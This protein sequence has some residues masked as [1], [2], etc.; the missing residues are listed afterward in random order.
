MTAAQARMTL[1][2]VRTQLGTMLKSDVAVDPLARMDPEHGS[3]RSFVSR[4]ISV[5]DVQGGAIDLRKGVSFTSDVHVMRLRRGSVQLAH[6]EGCTTVEAGQFVAYRGAQA[7]QFRHEHDIDMLGVFLPGS[8]LERF[9]PDWDAAEFV[10]SNDRAEGRLSFDIAHDLLDCADQLQDKAAAE[11]VGE[12]VARLLARALARS[13]LAEAAEPADLAEARRR[14][15]RHFCRKH[16]SS[17]H[18]S[19]D[20][21][22]RGTGLSRAAIHRLFHDQSHTLMQWVQLERLEVCRRVLAEASMVPATLTDIALAH[23]WK[24]SAHFSAAFRQRY[25]QSPRVYRAMLQTERA[26]GVVPAPT[27]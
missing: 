12:T 11:V 23:G 19:V 7:I 16:L 5:L 10:V 17:P 15:V 26:L 2:R 21:V 20:V 3:F 24:S 6:A 9:L 1:A 22:A 27:R 14:R 18:L 8:A 4:A 13:S 25:G